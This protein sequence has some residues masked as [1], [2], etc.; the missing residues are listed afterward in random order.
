M[1]TH[2]VGAAVV[3]CLAL[4]SP[5][6]AYLKF[7]VDLGD[8]VVTVRWN[9]LPVQYFIGDRGISGVTANAF[10]DA[11]GR[12]FA[13]WQDVETAAVAYRFT[14]FSTAEP[15]DFDGMNTI[16]FQSAPELDRVLAST[17]FVVDDVTGE[18]L[19]TDIFFNSAFNWSTAGAA[20]RY[21][22]ESIAVHEIGHLSGLGHSALGETELTA[23]G[24]RVIAAE[25]VMFPLA[26]SAGTT[27]GRTL[28]ADDIAGISDIYPDGGFDDDTGSI[29]GRV[30]LNGA[31]LLG[32]HVVAFNPATGKLVGGFTLNSNGGFAIL[33]L[34]AGPHVVRVEPLDDADVDSF[35]DLDEPLN[36][37]FRASFH[38]RL[39]VV[40]V[41]GDS[42]TVQIEATPR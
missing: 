9:Q 11:V 8:R 26:F 16:G 22:V 38:D 20:N 33:G 36:M 4:S 14:G 25:S 42:G 10:A 40:P 3:F 41:G 30:T 18:L 1:T 27:A 6:L 39:V 17:S 21:D 34:D 35:F 5:A 12:A 28:R 24:R 29:S 13:T 32:A 23:N 31:G 7:G 19:D 37:D 2:V 15:G